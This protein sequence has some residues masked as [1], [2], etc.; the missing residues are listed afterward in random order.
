MD[1]LDQLQ[2]TEGFIYHNQLTKKIPKSKKNV[3]FPSDKTTIKPN[4]MWN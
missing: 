3:D 2:A 4:I 1:C